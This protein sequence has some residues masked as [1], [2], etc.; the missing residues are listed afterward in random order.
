MVAPPRPANDNEP[1]QPLDT[2]LVFLLGPPGSGKT[3][4][5]SAVCAQLGLRFLGLNSLGFLLM[6]DGHPTA[7]TVL[8]R[9]T[10]ASLGHLHERKLPGSARVVA[11]FE[12]T[13]QDFVRFLRASGLVEGE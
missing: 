8:V 9:V 4:L 1:E 3:T 2:P 13:H 12:K 7:K 10:H 6:Y 11:R 5:G